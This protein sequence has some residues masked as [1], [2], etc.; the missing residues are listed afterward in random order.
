MV[1]WLWIGGAVM[2]IGTILSALPSRRSRRPTDPTSAPVL[3]TQH[4]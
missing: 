3:E 2:A 4:G 1:L